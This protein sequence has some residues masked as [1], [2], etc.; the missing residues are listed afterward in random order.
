MNIKCPLLTVDAV[1]LKD[2]RFV[3]IR[4]KNEPFKGLW[5]LPGGFVEAGEKV[6]DAARREAREETGL[7]IELL[8]L[9]GVYS[10]P[11]RDPRG[12]TVSI[13]YLAKP[14]GGELRAADDAEE[15]ALFGT[16]NYPDLA[17]DHA[18]ILNDAIDALRG[19]DL[20]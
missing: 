16:L 3:L 8:A 4:R 19:L 20:I 17:F 2:G 6:E 13:V 10:D 11:K 12:H 14:A 18:I 15:A 5:A 9:L 1:I 7:D